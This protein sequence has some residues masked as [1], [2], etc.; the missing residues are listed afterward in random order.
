MNITNSEIQRIKS[1]L[2]RFKL[3][4]DDEDFYILNDAFATLNELEAKRKALNKR[5]A[6]NLARKRAEDPLYG[7]SA[8]Y[9]QKRIAKAKQ[10]LAL[11]GKEKNYEKTL[12]YRGIEL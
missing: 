12:D 8:E 2:D 5:T 10:I 4:A 1:A 3:K 11:Y 6:K 7:R 9:K